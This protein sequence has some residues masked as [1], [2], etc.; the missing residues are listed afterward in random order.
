MSN[1]Q[2][3]APQEDQ[4]QPRPLSREEYLARDVF[5]NLPPVVTAQ[6]AST[7]AG[8][9]AV[10]LL[11]RPLVG[12]AVVLAT[13]VN[14]EGRSQ[15]LLE[16]W[17]GSARIRYLLTVDYVG[18]I[19]NGGSPGRCSVRPP[20]AAKSPPPAATPQPQ[21]P[22]KAPPAHLIRRSGWS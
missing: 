17:R 2:D 13:G 7:P 11:P 10:R 9:H 8:A 3:G 14:S 12:Q 5:A 1:R 15:V 16:Q 21:L 19:V 22:P 6:T 20:P 18:A 4:S